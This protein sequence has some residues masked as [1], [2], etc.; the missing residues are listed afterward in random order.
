MQN[1]TYSE[2]GEIAPSLLT[3][4]EVQNPL[5][6]CNEFFKKYSVETIGNSIKKDISTTL[7]FNLKRLIEACYIIITTPAVQ[8]VFS[9][10]SSNNPYTNFLAAMADIIDAKLQLAEY[11]MNKIIEEHEFR[12]FATRPEVACHIST[13]RMIISNCREV[14]QDSINN[15]KFHQNGFSHRANITTFNLAMFVDEITSPF[16]LYEDSLG[17]ILDVQNNITYSQLILSDKTM[18]GVILSC[19]LHIAFKH[20]AK[21]NMILLRVH[22]MGENLNLSV[23]STGRQLSEGNIKNLYE[24]VYNTPLLGSSG[25]I[26]L[27]LSKIFIE[28]LGGTIH[29]LSEPTETVIQV[30]VPCLLK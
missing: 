19:V 30:K 1:G 14:L 25:G 10:E 4:T 5:Q 11:S 23:K 12:I 26:N 18:L 9:L 27:Y 7:Q 21:S 8:P 15:V 16:R 20:S 22:S 24:P 6:V 13:F 28:K 17:K 3:R 29:I 2:K